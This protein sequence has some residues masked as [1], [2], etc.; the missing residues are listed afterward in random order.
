VKPA[1]VDAALLRHLSEQ[2]VEFILVPGAAAAARGSAGLATDLTIVYS[3]SGANLGRVASALAPIAVSLR[4]AGTGL[5]LRLD[6]ATLAAGSN[7]FLATTLG[8]IA[9][10]GALAG[11]G[12]YADLLAD[13]REMDVH[14]VRCRCLTPEKSKEVAS[15]TPRADKG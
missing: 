8:D 12:S 15:A 14:G 2:D 9:L 6:A 13:S 10:L 4:G 3:R 11:G 1:H 5:P 7:F